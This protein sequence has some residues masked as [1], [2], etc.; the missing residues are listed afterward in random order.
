MI[1][2]DPGVVPCQV[3]SQ[4][5]RQG[6]DPIRQI[7]AADQLLA[8]VA[9]LAADSTLVYVNAAAA[10]A[11]GQ[12]P[13][14][15]IGRRLFEL[16]HPGDRVRIRRELRRVVS[17]RSSGGFTTYRLR[18]DQT[19]EWRVF[20]S[21]AENLLDDP[22]IEG[23]L[24]SS[25]DVTQQQAHERE[26]YDAAY[27]DPL[28]GLPNRA[29]VNRR[30]DEIM[31]VDSPLAVAFV[32]ID[33]FTLIND[34]LGHALGDAVLQVMGARV[35][36][37]VPTTTLVGRY[38][39]DVLV[40][41]VAGPAAPEAR[42]LLWRVVERVGEPLFIAGHEL[43]ISLSAGIA[44]K[45]A[46]ATADSLLRDAGLALHRAKAGGGGRVEI[47]ES[48]MREAAI[49]RLELE[50]NLRTAIARSELSLA[51][52]PIVRLRDRVPV[53][54]E[55]LVR[56]RHGDRE[57]QPAEFIPVAEEVGLIVPLGDW[58]IDRAIQLAPHAPGGELTVNLSPRQLA[59][60]GLVDRIARALSA[61]RL[62]ASSL[63]FEVTETLLVDHY[64]YGAEVL[65]AIR[66]LGCRVG[67]DDFG[68]GYS[69][70]CYLRQLPL[71]FLKIDGSLSADID[72]NTEASAI[73]RA[74]ITM[75][76]A[77]GL[78][79]I[80]EGVETEAQ[81]AA[82]RDLG[83]PLAQGYLFGKPTEDTDRETATAAPGGRAR[84]PGVRRRSASR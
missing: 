14:W 40:L 28:T 64:D 22:S 21:I 52:Q 12:E 58:I 49:A 57:Y 25:R 75:A 59:A 2:N 62:P 1:R 70:L 9:V 15:L 76:D 47:F 80:A 61:R 13:A 53:R 63:S 74:I 54:A 79:V 7:P 29:E 46:T 39:A 8:P 17:G 37:S 5:P 27:R 26:L 83:C 4:A 66:Q 44:H 78:E 48:G 72:T 84:T 20:E 68:A 19:R 3:S 81:A 82:F 60:P 36:S 30:L 35:D 16:I 18:A 71:D 51:L 32:G 69:S 41:L 43:R 55:A 77:L 34:S 42:S 67:L 33:R 38:A 6:G 56:W 11:I 31:A 73:I 50:A 24:V 45:D 10:H 65:Y 23:I